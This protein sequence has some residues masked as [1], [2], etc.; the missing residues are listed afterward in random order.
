MIQRRRSRQG[1]GPRVQHRSG[2]IATHRGVLAFQARNRQSSASGAAAGPRPAWL[3]ADGRS[4]GRRFV[5][6]HRVRGAGPEPA[7]SR[8]FRVACSFERDSAFSQPSPRLLGR[9][10]RWGCLLA[11]LPILSYIGGFPRGDA[12]LHERTLA[13]PQSFEVGRCNPRRHAIDVEGSHARLLNAPDFG[14]QR[15]A[16]EDAPG[17]EGNVLWARWGIGPGRDPDLRR[18]R[19]SAASSGAP[20]AIASSRTTPN[21]SP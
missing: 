5:V 13:P 2:E 20:A 4:I 6:P 19:L 8:T 18:T 15:R 3:A 10:A 7:C 14:A 11:R 1:V 21:D 12:L 16:F 17:R 9:C